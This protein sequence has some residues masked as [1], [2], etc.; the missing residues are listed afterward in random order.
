LGY[1]SG[2]NSCAIIQFPLVVVGK[3]G[4]KLRHKRM[5]IKCG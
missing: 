2:G 3:T 4:L 1:G 5:K